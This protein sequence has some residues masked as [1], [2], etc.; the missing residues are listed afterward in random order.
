MCA[1][2]GPCRTSILLHLNFGA[3]EAVPVRPSAERRLTNEL[4]RPLPPKSVAQ[5]RC[6]EEG[7]KLLGPR[8]TVMLHEHVPFQC[9]VSDK[10]HAE[11]MCPRLYRDCQRRCLD[12]EPLDTA[13]AAREH[14][15][16]TVETV[17]QPLVCEWHDCN[18]GM[19]SAHTATAAAAEQK[20][21]LRRGHSCQWPGEAAE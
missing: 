10:R 7:Q 6:S 16:A 2:C 11:Q 12:S 17:A 20:H 21:W 8:W 13:R 18:A 9:K 4:Q 15:C 19:W 3:L 1:G 14:G 5:R